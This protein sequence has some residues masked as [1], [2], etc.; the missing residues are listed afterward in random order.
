MIHNT[1]RKCIVIFSFNF[2]QFWT[3]MLISVC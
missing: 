1:V 3:Q 2:C